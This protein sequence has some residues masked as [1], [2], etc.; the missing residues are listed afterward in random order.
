M[1]LTVLSMN[2]LSHT[3]TA[4]PGRVCL[5]G[6]IVNL[7]Y[8]LDQPGR[9][10]F[11]GGWH[12]LRPSG[13]FHLADRAAP[14]IVVF[15]TDTPVAGSSASS[16][17]VQTSST[18]Q[19]S[20]ASPDGRTTTGLVQPTAAPIQVSPRIPLSPPS[21]RRSRSPIASAVNFNTGLLSTVSPPACGAPGAIPTG[22]SSPGRGVHRIA[23]LLV[24]GH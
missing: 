13:D 22:Q 1:Y 8:D 23:V 15:I 21:L 2:R 16:T 7:D 17:L 9:G 3:V 18:D 6:Q 11:S 24:F 20:T 4:F 12:H 19:H 5:Q 10:A 14:T